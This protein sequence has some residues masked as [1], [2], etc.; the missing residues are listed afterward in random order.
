ML[1]QS[2]QAQV[3]IVETAG[4]A[5]VMATLQ[6]VVSTG[7]GGLVG[8]VKDV[9]VDQSHRGK[10]VGCMLLDHLQQ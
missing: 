10:G 9:V 7:E 5:A 3:F 1:L 8:W 6:I 4:Q 2:D